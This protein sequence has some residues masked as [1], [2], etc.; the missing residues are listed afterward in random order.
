MDITSS[1]NRELLQGFLREHTPFA[2][3][4]QTSLESLCQHAELQQ[5]AD[6]EILFQRDTPCERFYLLVEGKIKLL[7]PTNSK[8]GGRAIAMGRPGDGLNIASLFV[9]PAYHL[10]TSQSIGVS[11]VMAISKDMVMKLMTESATLRLRLMGDISSQLRHMVFFKTGFLSKC[12][13]RRVME[14]LL[15]LVPEPIRR[16]DVIVVLPDQKQAIAAR[17]L[18][19][20]AT[21]SRTLNQL[22][23][24]ELITVRHRQVKI[25]SLRNFREQM[26]D[27]EQRVGRCAQGVD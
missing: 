8:H 7:L 24:R 2:H 26:A 16:D 13:A 25:P 21:L 15:E 18:L 20:P 10:C 4:S 3:C 1:L 14:Y 19:E 12:A 5:V 17:L 23:E 27:W 11:W 9:E 6:G 22:Q